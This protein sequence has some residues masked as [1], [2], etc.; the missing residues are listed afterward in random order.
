MQGSEDAV[1]P[2]NQAEM[3]VEKIKKNKGRVEYVL[4]EGEGHGWRRAETIRAAL[5]E[6]IGFYQRILNLVPS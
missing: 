5:E 4:F 6:E 3:I 2:P 1:V